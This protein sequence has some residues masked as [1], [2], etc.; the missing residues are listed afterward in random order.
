LDSLAPRFLMGM[1]ATP[2][3]SDRED[4]SS[5]FGDPLYTVSIV[6]GIRDGYLADVDYKMLVDDFDW[7]RVTEELKKTHRL[8]VRDLNRYLFVPERDEEVVRRIA[9]EL[10]GIPDYR[11]LVYTRS[12]EHAERFSSLLSADGLPATTLHS[13]LDRFDRAIRLNRFRRHGRGIL[14]T[15][16][17]LN[18]GIDV[19]QV[20]VVV[21][22]RVTHSRTVFLQQLGRGLRIAPGKSRVIVLDF[23]SDIRRVAAGI[24]LNDSPL[25]EWGNPRR[26]PKQPYVLRAGR[27]VNFSSDAPAEFVRRYLADVADLQDSSDNTILRFPDLTL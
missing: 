22:L 10:G 3:R 9:A 24:E 17:M 15:V 18:E 7:T 12:I 2:W 8:T 1:T 13:D 6:E 11:C 21:F 19:P 26:S 14:V 27:V 16:D 23:V 20:N 25:D 5:I 4:P